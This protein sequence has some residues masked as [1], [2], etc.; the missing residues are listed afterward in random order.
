M[1]TNNELFVNKINAVSK[2]ILACSV[3]IFAFAALFYSTNNV[4]AND[5]PEFMQSGGKYHIQYIPGLNKNGNFYWH[6]MV[7]NNETGNFKVYYWDVPSQ[8]WNENFSGKGLPEL[9]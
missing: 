8:S 2:L 7:Y 3:L 6:V 4:I 5:M 1:R 9:P